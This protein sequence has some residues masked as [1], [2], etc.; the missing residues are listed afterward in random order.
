DQ[1]PAHLPLERI[2]APVVE[3]LQDQHP[4]DDGSGG[5]QAASASALGMALGQRLGDAIDERV[6]VEQGVD[7]SEGG[8][9]QLVRGGQQRFPEAA[10]SRSEERRVGKEW[11]AGWGRW[12]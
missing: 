11:R 6:V 8:I 12:S 7:A 1:A 9:P 5:P 4:Q 3:V 2:E 10:L